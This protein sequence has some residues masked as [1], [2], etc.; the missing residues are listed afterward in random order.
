MATSD[1]SLIQAQLP[2]QSKGGRD[3]PPCT[4]ECSCIQWAWL[5]LLA[6]YDC[7]FVLKCDIKLARLSLQLFRVRYLL[8]LHRL[9]E[10]QSIHFMHAFELCFQ[11][12]LCMGAYSSKH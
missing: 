3:T 12:Q 10:V 2:F 9:F 8:I 7:L 5:R 11:G 6:E 4:V 1:F